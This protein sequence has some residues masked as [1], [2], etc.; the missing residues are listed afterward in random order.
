MYWVRPKGK[1]KLYMASDLIF[2][3]NDSL[4]SD[5]WEHWNNQPQN[6]VKFGIKNIVEYTKIFRN[7]VWFGIVWCSD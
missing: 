5:S 7:N 2:N 1:S 4:N 3:K 6:T